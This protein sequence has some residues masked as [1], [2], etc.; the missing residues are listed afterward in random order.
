MK[1][2]K[3]LPQLTTTQLEIVNG[4][5]L[6]DGFLA[7]GRVN[8]NRNWIFGK[9]QSIFDKDGI[10]KE[11]YM[12][13]HVK[14]F[15]SHAANL[16]KRDSY[17]KIKN[18]PNGIENVKSDI[19]SK[20]YAFCTFRH[21]IWTELSKK[22]Y[23]RNND[24]LV[25]KN[26]KTVKIIPLDL[27]LTPLSVCIWFMDDGSLDAKNGNA[28]F[29]THGFTWSECEFL[30]ERLK[31]DVG[32]NSW[33]RNDWRG[34]PMI[35][36]GVS[37]HKDLIHLIKPHVDWDCFKYKLDDSYSKL[38]HVGENHSRTKLVEKD[39]LEII[40]LRKSGI[41]VKEIAK[42]FKM[43]NAAV[44]MITSGDRWRHLKTDRIEIIRKPRISCDKKKLIV[45]LSAT[46]IM[47]KD[48]AEITGV[49][50][51]TVSRILGRENDQ[52]IN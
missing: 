33:V 1:I 51:T 18:T 52:K 15:G 5:L 35:F 22:W 16:N 45:E 25:I 24:E 9:S 27:K 43:T 29:C 49:N 8:N 46:G 19:P 3:Q 21:P 32:I 20:S 23:L 26:N 47:Q 38:P 40:D 42:T 14:H 6:G 39:I 10:D 31:R 11:K 48:I 17:K 4:S 50:K 44:S 36:V 12:K 41:S 7:G 28:V 13:W 34:Y 30:V 37:S 2:H